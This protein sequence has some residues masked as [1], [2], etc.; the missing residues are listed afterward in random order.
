MKPRWKIILTLTIPLLVI[1]G[2]MYLR[3]FLHSRYEKARVEAYYQSNAKPAIAALNEERKSVAHALSPE[4]KRWAMDSVVK[5]MQNLSDY[6]ERLRHQRI[7]GYLF[8]GAVSG[9]G[10]I[11]VIARLD[12]KNH[13]A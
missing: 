11:L 10:M 13:E 8:L 4:K 2:G 1:G 7:M 6:K 5:H 3:L 12:Q 9:A